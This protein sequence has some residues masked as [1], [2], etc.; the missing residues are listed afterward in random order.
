MST[1]NL[2]TQEVAQ[3]TAQAELDKLRL[4]IRSLEKKEDWEHK[5][6]RYVP[7]LSVLI[8]VAGFT[9]GIYQFTEQ[10]RNAAERAI[11]EHKLRI[12]QLESDL[13]RDRAARM[14]EFHKLM[15]ERQ[16]ELYNE[17][18]RATGIITVTE[19]PD[20]KRS[21]IEK[22]SLLTNGPMQL[23]AAT[24]VLRA[25]SKFRTCLAKQCSQ[26]ELLKSS[27]ELTKQ[28]RISLARSYQEGVKGPSEESDEY[29]TN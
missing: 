4:E 26:E 28:M 5:I 9:F 21:E 13:E 22:L 29:K 20:V 6:G 2:A 19:N 1:N 10:Q 24:N 11:V 16:V 7:L 12:A 15:T 3:L 18:A 17:V 14:K 8:T 27:L 23:L 25:V